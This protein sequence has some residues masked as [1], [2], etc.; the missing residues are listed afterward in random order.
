MGATL[1]D[2]VRGIVVPDF[3]TMRTFDRDD[4]SK[5]LTAVAFAGLGGFWTLFYSYWMREKG[6][7]M[8]GGTGP[9][10]GEAQPALP[11]SEPEAPARLRA[12]HRYLSIESLTGIIGNLFTTLMSCLLAYAILRP[13]GLMPDQ[14]D[15]AVVQSE[16]FAASWGNAGRLLFLVIAGAFLA[17]T[18]LA[19]VDS[20]AH[21]S[22]CGE[23]A[24]ASFAKQD[25]V[26]R[27]RPLLRGPGRAQ[28]RLS[29]RADAA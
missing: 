14:F 2:F 18:W 22:R 4:A 15:I 25:R 17:D 21:A 26:R 16:F 19:T 29:A 24:L 7:G 1:G 3:D 11:A 5:L 8:A 20:V 9:A 28:P 12:W 23:R 10:G 13:R 6:I 27:D